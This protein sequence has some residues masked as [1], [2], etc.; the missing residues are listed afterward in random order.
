MCVS[1]ASSG[2]SMSGLKQKQPRLR[3]E[4]AAYAELCKQVLE[5][6]GW[7]CQNCGTPDNLQVH[8][9]NWRSRMGDD[10]FENLIIFCVCCHERLHRNMNFNCCKQT[11]KKIQLALGGPLNR[12]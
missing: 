8:H 7:R 3:L 11:H 12:V 6:D 10:C 1:Q 4:P 2:N 9:M 5:R